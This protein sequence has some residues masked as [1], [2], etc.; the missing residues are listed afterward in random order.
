VAL[1]IGK[2]WVIASAVDWPG[3]CRRGKGEDGALDT[4][5]EYTDRYAA[6]V[7]TAFD[8]TKARE[9]EVIG[10]VPGTMVTDLWA[11]AVVGPWDEEP[12]DA[13][14]AG[15]L[16]GLLDACWRHFDEV[17]AE[18][19][20]ELRKGPRGGGRD[21]DKMADHVLEADRSYFRK[22]DVRLLPRT[23]PEDLHAAVL[24]RVR[25]APA[26]TAW[27][28]RYLVRRSAWHALDHAWEMQDR[29]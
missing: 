20:A 10:S 24:E 9:L 29:S 8:E 26:A 12:L 22:I 27:P 19:P 5:L 7:G 1:E 11:P 17:V 3:W 21:R 13:R 18:S 16:A 14:E 6:V 4:L 23:K 28:V 15:R 2:R 25:E